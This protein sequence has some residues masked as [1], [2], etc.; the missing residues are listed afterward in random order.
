MFVY[1]QLFFVFVRAPVC[2][3]SLA[4]RKSRHET[5]YNFVVFSMF[6]VYLLAGHG[7]QELLYQWR[8]TVD[9][10]QFKTHGRPTTAALVAV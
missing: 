1:T 10:Q 7:P 9:W 5:E 2:Q 6:L 8:L 4:W 3:R